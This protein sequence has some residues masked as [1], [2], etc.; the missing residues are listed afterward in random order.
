[1][2]LQ[3][4]LQETFAAV[5]AL[6]SAATA[7]GVY[8]TWKQ[9]KLAREQARIQFEDQLS[10]EYRGLIQALPTNALLGRRLSEEDDCKAALSVFYRYFDLSNEQAF[11]Y[12]QKRVDE[13]T[14]GF[15]RA[16]IEQNLQTPAFEAAWDE[17]SQHAGD[18]FR[19]LQYHVPLARRPKLSAA[20]A[21]QI[22]SIVPS[23]PADTPP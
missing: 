5:S 13:K 17:I 14:W 7:I 16:G 4:I 10:A 21:Q 18:R 19:E 1:M 9:I 12:D 15:W 3:D 2:T 22:R 23:P 20:D 6:A 8:F 11:L